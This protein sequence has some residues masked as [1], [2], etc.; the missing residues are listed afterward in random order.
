MVSA[1]LLLW[2]L[3][4][5]VLVQRAAELWLAR[6]HERWVR[7]RGAREFGAGHYP[8][9]FVLHGAWLVAWPLEA[10]HR[11]PALAP[12]W[13]LWLL[14][15]SAAQALRYWAIRSLGSRWNT[16]ILV[17]PGEPPIRR[18]PYRW[19]SHRN[20][21]AVVIELA[22]LPLAFGA[23]WTAGIFGALNLALLLGVRIPAEV[24]AWR[25]SRPQH[26]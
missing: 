10:V 14:L 6:Q 3:V 13:T 26:D 17:I 24:R 22:A 20:Y 8:A 2:S 19:G 7:A 25:E 12:G 1:S 5:A 16:R 4:T 15:F 23:Y 21:I 11:G 9:F 18:G